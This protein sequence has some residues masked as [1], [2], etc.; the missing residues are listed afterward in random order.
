MLQTYRGHFRNGYFVPLEEAVIPENVEV[1][2]VITDNKVPTVVAKAKNQLSA[3]EEFAHAISQAEPFGED[4][5]RIISEGIKL[6]K[7]VTV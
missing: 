2:V 1:F 4:F 5:D 6:P 3:F 7:E